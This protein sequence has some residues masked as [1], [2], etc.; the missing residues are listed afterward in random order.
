MQIAL[1]ITP[2]LVVLGWIIGVDMSL[3]FQS[4]ETV[5]LFISVLITNYLIQ[6]GKSNWL[7]GG[8]LIATYT[9]IGL[10]FFFYPNSIEN[11]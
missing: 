9:I 1:F 5:V 3:Y 4:F 10:A 8:M 7:E 6:D 11:N 2:F